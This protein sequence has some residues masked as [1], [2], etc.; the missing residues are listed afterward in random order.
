MNRL[1]LILAA[2]ALAAVATPA[3]AQLGLGGISGL[4]G[5]KEQMYP[6]TVGV[7]PR[8]DRETLRARRPTFQS[9]QARPHGAHWRWRHRHPHWR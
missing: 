6:S 3:L 9:I 1:K 4:G 2:G 5:A 8:P 7:D